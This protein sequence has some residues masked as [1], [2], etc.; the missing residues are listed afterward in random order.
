MTN[1]GLPVMATEITNIGEVSFMLEAVTVT[2]KT[3]PNA[4]VYVVFIILKLN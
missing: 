4:L 1:R 2:C 3:R